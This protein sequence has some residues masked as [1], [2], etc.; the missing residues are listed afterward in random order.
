MTTSI[1]VLLSSVKSLPIT[2]SSPS[3]F[4]VWDSKTDQS[5]DIAAG[6]VFTVS[7]QDLSNDIVIRVRADSASY[8]ELTNVDRM[9]KFGTKTF[10]DNK[11][12]GVI[13]FRQAGTGV[14]AINELPLEEYMKG[15]AEEPESDDIP[16]EKRKVIAVLSRSY[17]LHYLV[18][19]YEKFSG[20]PYN[21]SDDPAVFQKYLGYGFEERSP[22]WQQTLKDTEG[23]VLFVDASVDPTATR[24]ER[25]LRAA[26]F[27]CTDASPDGKSAGALVPRTKTPESAGWSEQPYFKRFGLVFASVEDPLGDDPLRQGFKDCG[28]QVGLSGYGATQ[29]AKQGKGY[30]EIIEF[31]YQKVL[32]EQW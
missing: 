21:A 22:K 2:I 11:Y 32:I 27:S 29:M 16:E 30:R 1:R 5:R 23:E 17:A 3:L 4:T 8:L 19:G 7:A 14:T 6:E 18:S 25:V 10:N 9:K 28:H 20:K 31:Y 15:I 12:R 26:Y 24:Q 13:E